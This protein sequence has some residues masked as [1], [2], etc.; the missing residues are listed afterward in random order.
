MRETFALLLGHFDILWQ[1]LATTL[2]VSLAAILIAFLL[3]G[4]LAWSTGGTR[5]F[6]SVPARAFIDLM[7]ALPFVLVLLLVHFGAQ[8]FIGRIP[9][10]IT[11]SFALALYG[12][13]YFSEALRSAYVAVP[14]GQMEAAHTLGLRPAVAFCK[15][16]APQMVAVFASI[17]RVVAIML[18]KESAVLS[19]IT[20]P[21]LTHAALRIQAESFK[22]VP[23]FLI[24]TLCYWAAVTLLSLAAGSL[25]QHFSP[26]HRQEPASSRSA[27]GAPRILPGRPFHGR[28]RSP[29]RLL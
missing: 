18:L 29:R 22:T 27:A 13:A 23:T 10:T 19:M 20:V 7:R 14:R 28:L 16:I 2:A 15:V 6:L 12:S 5:H 24:V 1:G 17:G 3:A 21:E 11:G 4:P 9:G 26:K 8:N 25:E